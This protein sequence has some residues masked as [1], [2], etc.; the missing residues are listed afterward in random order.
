M[1]GWNIELCLLVTCLRHQVVSYCGRNKRS[2]L[3]KV[4]KIVRLLFFK[5]ALELLLPLWMTIPEEMVLYSHLQGIGVITIQLGLE[6][7]R[8]LWQLVEHTVPGDHGSSCTPPHHSARF[9]DSG[10]HL[11][12]AS[13]SFVIIGSDKIVF[14]HLVA[15]CLCRFGGSLNSNDFTGNIPPSIGNL[16]NLY[17][18]DLFDN[19][20]YTCLPNR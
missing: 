13:A 16:K 20:L 8:S 17:W 15:K 19:Q 1:M 12:L 3:K 4:S 10:S 5:S 18:L 14:H 6:Q 11:G 7:C 2:R 9:I